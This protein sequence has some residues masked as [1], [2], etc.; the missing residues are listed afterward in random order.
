MAAPEKALVELIK[1]QHHK[2][3]LIIV[4]VPQQPSEIKVTDEA[5]LA[6]LQLIELAQQ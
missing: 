5:E 3:K 2:E 6:S 1:D 4:N